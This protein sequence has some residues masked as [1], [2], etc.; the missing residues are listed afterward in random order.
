MRCTAGPQ[1]RVCTIAHC[2][3]SYARVLDGLQRRPPSERAVDSLETRG[4]ATGPD[5]GGVPRLHPPRLLVTPNRSVDGP[6][7]RPGAAYAGRVRQRAPHV[8]PLDP[9]DERGSGQPLTIRPKLDRSGS[10][11]R[12]GEPGFSCLECSRSHESKLHSSSKPAPVRRDRGWPSVRRRR[13]G[14]G[15]RGRAQPPL[16]RAD[17]RPRRRHGMAPHSRR[18]RRYLLPHGVGGRPW[19]RRPATPLRSRKVSM[20]STARWSTPRQRLRRH[21]MAAGRARRL[22]AHPRER[23]AWMAQPRDPPRPDPGHR[24]GAPRPLLCG[25]RRPFAGLGDAGPPTP[26]DIRRVSAV[27][28]KYGHEFKR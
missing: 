27:M 13:P 25:G 9:R 12:A 3:R 5:P 1:R 4:A 23:L 11:R 7:R 6:G 2:D 8:R 20:S 26:E 28:A 14:P 17:S 16:R 24:S 18:N 22:R 10:G 21:G 19:N 15:P